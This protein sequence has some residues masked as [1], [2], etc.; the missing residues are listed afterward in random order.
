MSAM[1]TPFARFHACMA[2]LSLVASPSCHAW[3]SLRAKPCGATLGTTHGACDASIRC[4]NLW[5][6]DPFLCTTT[7]PPS[8]H[9]RPRQ[10]LEM[11]NSC[12][13]AHGFHGGVHVHPHTHARTCKHDCQLE[14]VCVHARSVRRLNRVSCAL[15]CALPRR[16]SSCVW[17]RRV[18]VKER[19]W[20][21]SR[22]SPS[23]EWGEERCQCT[24]TAS[25]WRR[26]AHTGEVGRR[27][28]RG[29]S[30]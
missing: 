26:G 30:R 12:L 5:H 3:T 1:K 2:V 8:R 14:C 28:G 19:R 18:E 4:L 17:V 23:A 20:T 7:P 6:V 27:V 13:V 24:A 22:V 21:R 10:T 25:P 29:E 16:A 9:T 11:R 15:V